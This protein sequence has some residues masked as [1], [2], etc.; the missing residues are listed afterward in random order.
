M[1]T[2]TEL[3]RDEFSACGVLDYTPKT[4]AKKAKESAKKQNGISRFLKQLFCQHYW[5]ELRD[6]KLFINNRVTFNSHTGYVTN[7]YSRYLC[8][9]ICLN[10]GKEENHEINESDK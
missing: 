8:P 9:C 6:E 3:Y 4:L 10:C 2:Y 7:R 5:Y 1:A